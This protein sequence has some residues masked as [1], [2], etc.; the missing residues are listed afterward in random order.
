MG[1]WAT[2]VLLLCLLWILDWCV[3][4]GSMKV[5]PKAEC[6]SVLCA[7]QG[8]RKDKGLAKAT[9]KKKDFLFKIRIGNSQDR[10]CWS[11]LELLLIQRVFKIWGPLNGF[12]LFF[13]ARKKW[14]SWKR[15]VVSAVRWHHLDSGIILSVENWH[16]VISTTTK[17]TGENSHLEHLDGVL[18]SVWMVKNIIKLYAVTSCL[19]HC[20]DLACN[21]FPESF[22]TSK[23]P[24]KCRSVAYEKSE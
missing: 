24:Q 8:E 23:Q 13:L 11:L 16:L 17:V 15:Q 4:W 19:T 20:P 9:G 14:C 21:A 2:G 1:R 18:K 10:V 12:I 3:C 7:Y 5:S 6:L 22:S